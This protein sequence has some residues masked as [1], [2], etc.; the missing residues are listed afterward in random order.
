[1]RPRRSRPAVA[2]LL[3]GALVG[4]AAVSS[5]GRDNP[6]GPA[7]ARISAASAWQGLVSASRPQV[8]VGQRVLVVLDS[9]SLADRV[10]GAGGFA[11]DAEERTWTAAAFA[12]QQQLISNLGRKGVRVKP[13]FRYTRV[14]NGFSAPLDAGTIA[15]LEHDPGVQGVYPV[16]IAYP[17]SVSRQVLSHGLVPRMPASSLAG[18]DGTGVTIALLDTGVD[19]DKPYLHGHVLDGIDVVDNGPDARIKADPGGSGRLETHGTE[20]AGLLIGTGGPGG[21]AGVVPYA[22]VLPIR[23]AGWQRTA[24]GSWGVY[25][26]TDQILAGLEDAVDP[27]GDGDAHDAARVAL[28]PLAE[29]YAA[30]ADGPVAQAVAGAMALDTLVVV[31]AGNDGPAGSVF[32]SISGPGGAPDALTVGAADTR[33]LEQT[34]RLVVR[35]GLAILLDRVVPLAG[36]VKLSKTIDVSVAVPSK[37][38]DTPA[39]YFGRDGVSLVAGK[40]ALVEIGASPVAQVEAAARAGAAAVLLYGS[41]LPAGGLGLDEAVSVPVVEIPDQTALALLGAVGRGEDAQVAL[42]AQ[43]MGVFGGFDTI[44]PFGSWGLA[45]NGQL[46]PEVSGPGVVL[47][48]SEP[49][50]NEDGTPRFG[51]VSGSSAAAAV[52][53]GE[54]ALLLEARPS[55]DAPTVRSLL[56][57]TSRPLAGEPPAAQGAGLV[58]AGAAAAAE[59]ALH[60]ATVSFGRGRGDGWQK[61]RVLTIRNISTRRLSIYVDTGQGQHPRVA[62]ALSPSRV[63]VASG[64]SARVR[65]TARILGYPSGDAAYGTLIVTPVGGFSVR[66]PWTVVL[67]SGH[68]LIYAV[69]LSRKTFKPSASVPAVLEFRAG[70]VV[71]TPQGDE[72]QPLI[73]LDV[74]LWNAAG[75]ELGLLARLRDVLPG[76]YALGLTGHGPSGGLLAPGAYHLRLVGWPTAGGAPSVVT[77]PFSIGR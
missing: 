9:P 15:L 37:P 61:T 70:S 32:G 24:T 44:A 19:L 73:R 66:V 63:E 12:A 33:R 69:R 51:T 52:V 23:V 40:A 58:D 64:G 60:P 45:F 54:A 50:S 41:P 10:A 76:R 55:L 38:G 7:A 31:P 43:R 39:D 26:R 3:L 5:A 53:A 14:L 42:G 2:L 22:T 75:K 27:N 20:M 8:A 21:L 47:P 72:V 36:A 59:L 25:A 29:P 1:M 17:A 62:I 48:T 6:S 34:V 4:A 57:E 13:E 56:V 28:V 11:S 18:Y 35:R 74:E 30:F 67:A 71:H 68:N 46:K 16:R 77:V 65:L 49:G